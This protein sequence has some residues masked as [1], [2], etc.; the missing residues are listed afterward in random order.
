[1]TLHEA[2]VLLETAGV[3]SANIVFEVIEGHVEVHPD[4]ELYNIDGELIE[5][6]LAKEVLETLKEPVH[7]KYS[8]CILDFDVIDGILD[9]NIPLRKGTISGEESEIIWRE[10]EEEIQV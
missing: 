4:V 7:E 9:W 1:M 10:F 8:G 2:F 5:P 6:V 3:H